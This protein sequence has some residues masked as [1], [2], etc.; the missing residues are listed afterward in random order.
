MTIDLEVQSLLRSNEVKAIDFTF[1]SLRIT[2]HGFW[3]LSHRFSD[4]FMSHRIRVTVRPAIVGRALSLY[5]PGSG[6]DGDKLNLRSRDTLNTAF[7]RASVVHECTHALMDM[8]GL[9]ARIRS[10]EGAAFI[11]QAWY[12]LNA[13]E[14]LHNPL[15]F[16][17]TGEIIM[18]AH[19]LRT[20][21][22]RARGGTV[23]L[24]GAQVTA[25]RRS[26][27]ETYGYGSGVYSGDGIRGRR[28]RGP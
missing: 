24:T 5:N 19:D 11:A 1:A 7:G 6:P 28:F 25:A 15:D 13:N 10:E 9:Q 21:S 14:D 16:N 22:I 18:I 2:G 20:R 23:A 4:T 8:R 27:A 12:L 3:E 26:M 17:L